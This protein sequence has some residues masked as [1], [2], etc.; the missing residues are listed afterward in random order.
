MKFTRPYLIFLNPLYWLLTVL[1]NAFFDIGLLHSTYFEEPVIVI[2]NLSTGGTGK[3]PHTEYM[4][5]FLRNK[6]KL[7]VLSRGYRRKSTGYKVAGKIPLANLVGDEPAQIKRKFPDVL[8]AVDAHRVH[9]IKQL[10]CEVNKP[11]VILLDD[12]FQHRKLQAG[13]YILLTDYHH[14]YTMDALLPA[15]NLRETKGGADRANIIVVS[16]CPPDISEPEMKQITAEL[17]P[18]SHQEVFFTTIEY[19]EVIGDL[20]DFQSPFLLVTGIA[21]AAQM[22]AYL[23]SQQSRFQHL[24]FADHHHFSKS[25]IEGM[26]EKAKSLK[27]KHI[28]TTEKDVQRL[29][30]EEFE[31]NGM[32]VS[33]LPIQVKFIAHEAAFQRNVTEYISTYL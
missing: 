8:V 20:P 28:L 21:N 27:T 7:A 30:L 22:V 5:R 29:P 4:I 14:R 13:M 15:G 3:T 17:K 23:R 25:E 12:A 18:R 9:G 33:Y 19:G 31:K 6:Y 16:K 11:E 10:L 26:M 32:Y 2:G 24:N 1:R